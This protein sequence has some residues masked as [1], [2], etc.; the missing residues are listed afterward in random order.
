MP[1]NTNSKDKAEK[2]SNIIASDRLYK[3]ILQI[4][5]NLIST[6]SQ[7][8]LEFMS[9]FCYFSEVQRSEQFLNIYEQLWHEIFVKTDIREKK[10]F[11]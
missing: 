6:F 4:A 3:H 8:P 1:Q 9:T 7:K 5:S 11:F 2:I 10:A